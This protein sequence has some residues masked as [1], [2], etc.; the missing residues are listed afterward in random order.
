MKLWNNKYVRPPCPP[1]PRAHSRVDTRWKRYIARVR[2]RLVDGGDDERADDFPETGCEERK[3]RKKG[4]G[5]NF[6]IHGEDP[7]ADALAR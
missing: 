6:E 1:S 2:R 4:N 7:S 3:K 5:W